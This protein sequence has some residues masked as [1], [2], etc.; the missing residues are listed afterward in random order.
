LNVSAD[1]PDTPLVGGGDVDSTSVDS[2]DE[3]VELAAG[4]VVIDGVEAVPPVV[5]VVA[6]PVVEADF[7]SLDEQLASIA[8]TAKAHAAPRN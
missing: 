2:T 6:V 5:G 8:M 3:T 1:D 4:V 7:D